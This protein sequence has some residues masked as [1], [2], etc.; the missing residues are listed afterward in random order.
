MRPHFIAPKVRIADVWT[1]DAGRAQKQQM[2]NRISS[3]GY[4]LIVI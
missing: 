3:A 4:G 1:F 2:L